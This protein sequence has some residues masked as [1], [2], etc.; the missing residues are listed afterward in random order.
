MKTKIIAHRGAS[1]Q[2][3]ENTMSAFQLA[4]DLQADG[5]ELDVMLT[6]DQQV[7]VIHDDTVDR[8]TNGT[9]QVADM[10]LEEIRQLDAGEGE[11]IPTLSEVLDRFGGKCLINIELKNYTSIFNRLPVEVSN[12]LKSHNLVEDILVSSFNPFNLPRVRRRIPD[13]SL[14]LITQ[15]QQAKR[16]IWRFFEYDALHPH[17]DDVDAIIVSALHARNREVNV[18]TV[19]DPEE[20]NRVVNLDVDGIITNDP[21]LAREVLAK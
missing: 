2:A 11:K 8:T 19:D 10:T 17:F 3:P 12:L 6:A 14:G 13:I 4:L 21:K 18:W 7:V 5:I 15:P 20:I 1:A 9:G 16:W